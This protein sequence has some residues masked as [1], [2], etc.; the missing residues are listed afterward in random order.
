MGSG[1]LFV[2]WWVWSLQGLFPQI[3][4][5]IRQ[6][7]ISSFFFLFLP[8]DDFHQNSDNF[9]DFC[10]TFFIYLFSDFCQ[11]FWIFVQAWIRIRNN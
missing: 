9:S 3:S 11:T 2:V 6:I 10:N 1:S 4:G 7:A 8:N 5:K